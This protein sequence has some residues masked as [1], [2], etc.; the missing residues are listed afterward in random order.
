M[1]SEEKTAR[2]ETETEIKLQDTHTQFQLAII[3]ADDEDVFR[4]CIN[5]FISAARSVTMVMEKETNKN[6]ELLE[7]YKTETAEFA[8]DPVMMFFNSQRVHTVHLGNVKP[9]S[10]SM[11][12]RNIQGE[13]TAD[14]TMMSLWV[15]DNVEEFLPGET[16]NVFRLCDHYLQTLAVMVNEWRYLKDVI[17]NPR[18]VIDGLQADRSR[19]RGQINLMRSEL[20]Q[21][22]LTLEILNAAAK[23]RGDLSEDS[24]V[25]SLV[26]RIDRLLDREKFDKA[27][28]AKPKKGTTVLNETGQLKLYTILISPSEAGDDTEGVYA[29]IR[30]DYARDENG[31]PIFNKDWGYWMWGSRLKGQ[32]PPVTRGFATQK[33]AEDAAFRIY[34]TLRY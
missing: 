17:E 16:G 30:N 34:K 7:W 11:P 6:P 26:N 2:T 14:D 27:N 10:H 25:N 29:T 32:L 31:E 15:F 21:A 8:T 33:E 12:V 28:A 20:Q 1:T 5:S 23:R 13:P 9:K 4:S 24:F 18:G 19:M 22:K 3:H